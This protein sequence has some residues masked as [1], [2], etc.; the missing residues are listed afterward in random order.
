L[1]GVVTKGE[2][3]R[4]R[5]H[6]R[7]DTH[8]NVGDIRGRGLFCGVELVADKVSKHPFESSLNINKRIKKNAMDL[9]LICYPMGG[10]VVGQ[11][12]DHVL[13]APPF[14]INDDEIDELVTLLTHA[15]D[16]SVTAS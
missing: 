11:H 10:T 8:P 16:R 15:I 12:G 4:Q 14:I 2:A 6:D 13:I 1:P 3:L 9:G 7:L 5:L